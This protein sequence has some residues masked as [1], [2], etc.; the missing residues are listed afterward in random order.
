[1]PPR[2]PLL[3]ETKVASRLPLFALEIFLAN[4]IDG[5]NYRQI[6]DQRGISIN[7]VRHHMLKA[8]RRIA[9]HREDR[10]YRS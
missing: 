8:I 7:L 9:R 1:M 5:L 10:F 4:R 2:R 3:G 6:A